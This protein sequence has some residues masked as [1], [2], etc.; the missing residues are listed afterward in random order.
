MNSNLFFF[1]R[2]SAG[3]LLLVWALT[4]CA[5]A[6]Q[7][8]KLDLSAS[9]PGLLNLASSDQ[10]QAVSPGPFVDAPGTPYPYAN[11]GGTT[12][13]IGYNASLRAARAGEC[14]Q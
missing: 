10:P 12:L 7:A 14:Q 6:V 4:L 13:I 8:G 2:R 3:A 9:D 11:P 1:P 5:T